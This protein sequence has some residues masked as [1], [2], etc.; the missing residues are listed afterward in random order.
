MAPH[1]WRSA[2]ILEAV[3]QVNEHLVSA[4][5]ELAR[6]ETV[7]TAVVAQNRDA[8]RQM[9][10]ASCKRAARIPVLLLDLHFHSAD[11]WHTAVG[12]NGGTYPATAGASSLPVDLAA[13]LTRET[14]IVGWLAVR[15]TPQSANLLF[16]MSGAV[17]DLLGA[18][19]A[20]QLDRVA[21]RK[22]HELQVRWQHNQ[23]FWQ[24]LLAAG[25]SGNAEELC[26]THLFGLQLLGGEVMSAR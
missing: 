26:E 6:H 13:E 9:E 16:G 20:Q 25:R 12:L 15:E 24:R 2:R 1:R 19:S 14:L 21:V 3:C 18:L 23:E 4:L 8:L 11:W 10:A 7:S 22:S 5:S 17:A